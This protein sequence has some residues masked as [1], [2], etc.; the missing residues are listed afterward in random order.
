[1]SCC[2][3]RSNASSSESSQRIVAG[4]SVLIVVSSILPSLIPARPPPDRKKIAGQTFAYS[5][6]IIGVIIGFA[7]TGFS[8]TGVVVATICGF[9]AAMLAYAIGQATI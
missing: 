2:L 4:V 5:G 1:M 9:L 7:M 6:F 3:A 8:I